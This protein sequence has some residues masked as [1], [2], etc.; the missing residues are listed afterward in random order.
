[1]FPGSASF[2]GVDSGIPSAPGHYN[3]G[4]FAG[5]RGEFQA[6]VTQIP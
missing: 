4:A 2:S 6:Q 1:V 3:F 5:L